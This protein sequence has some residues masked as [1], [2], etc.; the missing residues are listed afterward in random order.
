[1]SPYKKWYG[2]DPNLTNV[3]VWGCL[4][5]AHVALHLRVKLNAKTE[6]I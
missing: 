4:G 3:K 5:Y 1:M 6:P 2:H